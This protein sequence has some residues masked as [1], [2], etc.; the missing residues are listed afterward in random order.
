MENLLYSL[1]D[2]FDQM[3]YLISFAGG[4]LSFFSPCVLPLAPIYFFY[5]TGL[6]AGELQER[7][8]TLS[9]RWQIFWNSLLFV[10]G[11]GTIFLL[12]GLA[13]ANV[14]GNIFSSKW[15]AGVAGVVIIL[16]GLHLGGFLRF[17]FLQF[18]KRLHLEN[19][20]GFLLGVS[21]ALGW[22]PCIGP[23]FGTI[24]GLASTELERALPLMLL[25][26]FGL[27]LPFLLMALFTLWSFKL[28][29]RFKKYL[30]VI[31]KVSGLILIGVGLWIL[32]KPFL[33]GF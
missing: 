28:L 11:F 22:T 2:Y 31:E 21:F 14:I 1:F 17:R 25:Y 26:I 18:E 32:I 19:V 3:P 9:E 5:I 6:S 33:R 12:L 30:G 4:L 10:A 27:A 29:D 13:A 16:F 20:G 7:G 24:V 15:V 23:I 8:L